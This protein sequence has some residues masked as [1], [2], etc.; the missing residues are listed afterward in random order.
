MEREIAPTAP[1]RCLVGLRVA[2]AAFAVDALAVV[3]V[4]SGAPPLLPCPRVGSSAVVGLVEQRGVL[5][6]VV[7]LRAVFGLADARPS[8][9]GRR[10]VLRVDGGAFAVAVDAVTEVFE[11][12]RRDLRPVLAGDGSALVR[13]GWAVGEETA[14]ELDV[15]A[16]A[17]VVTGR[18]GTA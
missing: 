13:A 11:A 1:V 8:P 14:L 16:L 7:D 5:I 4:L 3:V 15:R 12:R 6:P 10:V 2:A 9:R 18:G 17:A